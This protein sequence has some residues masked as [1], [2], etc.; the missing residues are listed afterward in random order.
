MNEASTY[1][2]IE[3]AFAEP[4]TA[5]AMAN[6]ATDERERLRLF[7]LGRATGELT[8]ALSFE[9]MLQDLRSMGAPQALTRLAERAI[10][11]EHRHVDWCLRFARLLS[12]G[13]AVQAELA[14]T[15]PLTFDGASETDQ[16]LLRTVFGG[17]F[18]ETVA[19]HVLLSSQAELQLA[20]VQQLNR[21][22]V[23]EEV[24]HARLGW[25]LLAWPG[26]GQRDR[27]MLSEFV[28]E[29]ARLT[30]QVWCG[31]GRNAEPALDALGYLSLSLVR[32]ACQDAFDR[33]IYPGLS[34]NG[35]EV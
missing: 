21:Q 32:T 13:Q 24:Q 20:S 1:H 31:S 22:H 16:R 19:V 8:T 26:L 15:R 3:L 23:R 17:C 7:W 25:G 29:M 9:Y 27:A 12:D 10:A 30:W 14:G 5:L 33:V 6:L 28:P 11:D 4:A 35:V 18:S 2:S 34:R